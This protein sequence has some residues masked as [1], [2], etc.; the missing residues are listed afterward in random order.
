MKKNMLAKG[1]KKKKRRERERK[2]EN[3][4][5]T[6]TDS[7]Y[8]VT[9]EMLIPNCTWV[10]FIHKRFGFALEAPDEN[11]LHFEYGTL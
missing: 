4:N 2:K 8:N 10:Y 7:M 6:K 11:C 1:K 9:V 5:K 3:E